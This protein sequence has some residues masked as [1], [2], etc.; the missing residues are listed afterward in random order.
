M[1]ITPRL[2]VWHSEHAGRPSKTDIAE[3]VWL[4]DSLPARRETAQKG[5]VGI[6]PI[7]PRA[8]FI[9]VAFVPPE[10][11][12]RVTLNGTP[13]W[14]GMHGLRHG[15]RLALG[16]HNIWVAASKVAEPVAYDP[17]VHGEGLVCCVTRDRLAP[18]EQIVR[19]P[20]AGGKACDVIYK[21]EAWDLAMQATPPMR[22]P[23][24]N[25]HP[26]DEQWEPPRET[27]KRQMHTFLAAITNGKH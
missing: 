8:N 18:G 16:G 2:C 13:L 21:K 1:T 15:D 10:L 20:G 19:C 9:G 7:V 22:C 11:D 23:G 24:C 6:R 14:S 5:A 25:F 3:S 12:E 17:A 4:S 27:A 26:G